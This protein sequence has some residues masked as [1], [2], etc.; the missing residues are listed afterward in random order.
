VSP[1]DASFCN[2]CSI[3]ICCSSEQAPIWN[4]QVLITT[5]V[6]QEMLLMTTTFHKHESPLLMCS[7][8]YTKLKVLESLNWGQTNRWQWIQFGRE[9]PESTYYKLLHPFQ[10]LTLLLVLC[11]SFNFCY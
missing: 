10:F 8:W 4:K 11:L 9:S 2:C 5:N 6:Q 3:C 7:Q 1:C